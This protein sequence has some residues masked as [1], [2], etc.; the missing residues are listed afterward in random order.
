MGGS[1]LSA[2][3]CPPSISTPT[4]PVTSNSRGAVVGTSRSLPRGRTTRPPRHGAYEAAFL[5]VTQRGR[6]RAVSCE[7]GSRVAPPRGGHATHRVRPL[8][9]RGDRGKQEQVA[10]LAAGPDPVL[11]TIPSHGAAVRSSWTSLARYRPDSDLHG[12]APDQWKEEGRRESDPPLVCPR[13]PGR[14]HVPHL[15]PQRRQQRMAPGRGLLRLG[16]SPEIRA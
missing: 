15:S 4:N 14:G 3:P 7:P 8:V 13:R 1:I 6:H 10:S 12:Q 16:R 5:P 2:G 9:V 11:S